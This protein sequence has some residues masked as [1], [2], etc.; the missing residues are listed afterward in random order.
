[1]QRSKPFAR[2]ISMMGLIS[3][4][5]AAFPMAG[6]AQQAALAEIGPYESRGKG[7]GRS[8]IGSGRHGAHMTAVRAAR[9]ARNVRRHKA[10]AH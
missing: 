6:Q 3:A 8:V 4:A 10:R 7:R 2:A 5:M 1:M 9:K